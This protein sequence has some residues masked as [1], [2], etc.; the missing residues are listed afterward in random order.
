MKHFNPGRTTLH[1]EAAADSSFMFA[2]H[3]A[4]A[5]AFERQMDVTFNHQGTDYRIDRELLFQHF[6]NEY[7][8]PLPTATPTVQPQMTLGTMIARLLVIEDATQGIWF[9]HKDTPTAPCPSHHEFGTL[10]IGI[11]DSDKVVSVAEFL[12]ICSEAIDADF[13]APG[14]K[15]AAGTDTPLLAGDFVMFRYHIIRVEERASGCYIITE[16]KEPAK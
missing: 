4:I 2:A 9:E 16:Y 8:Q 12:A 13:T 5:I 10:S 15:F 1:L 11:A 3:E 6:A 7:D 14:G